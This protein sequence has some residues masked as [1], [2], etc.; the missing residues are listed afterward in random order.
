VPTNCEPVTPSGRLAIERATAEVQKETGALEDSWCSY[1]TDQMAE[2]VP[3]LRRKLL[4][5]DLSRA[6]AEERSGRPCTVMMIDIDHFKQANTTLGHPGADEVLIGVADI[7]R[8]IVGRRGR[9][10]R[11]GGEEISVL[12]PDF[13]LAEARHG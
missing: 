3:I 2:L 10:Y 12:L 9:V 8:G 6:F 13:T 7:I 11:Y 4:D 1:P 5:E